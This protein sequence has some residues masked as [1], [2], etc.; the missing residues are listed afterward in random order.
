MIAAKILKSIQEINCPLVLD[1]MRNEARFAYAALPERFFIVHDGI[2]EYEGGRGPGDYKVEE[3][4][5]WLKNYR[6][7]KK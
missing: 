1:T 3:V 4:E 5:D 7:K 6:Q 2:I